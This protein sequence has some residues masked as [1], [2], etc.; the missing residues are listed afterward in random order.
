M[1]TIPN[2]LNKMVDLTLL[3]P[4]TTREELTTFL[5]SA[6]EYNPM[7]V[8]I[9]PLW[10]PFARGTLKKTDIKT[11][12]VIGFPLGA[13]TLTSK[14][15]ETIDAVE[16][17]AD[18]IDYVINISDVKSGYW[19]M[20]KTEMNEIVIAA[21]TTVKVIL[22]TC[23]LTTE[24]I[25]KVCEIA[26]TTGIDFVKTS[27]GFGTGGATVANVRIMAESFGG[28]VKA[29]GGIRDTETAIE[30]IKAGATRLGTSAKLGEEKTDYSNCKW[31][32]KG[33]SEGY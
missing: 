25:V 2:K 15:N 8:C 16:N 6:I 21:K 26:K 17:G 22:E 3:K 24:E 29:S 27:T 11:C 9:N 10:I 20:I 14:I 1:I 23:Y 33:E 5:D 12:T 28:D 18:E 13:N 32:N 30:M 31:V 19:A 4:T 7:S